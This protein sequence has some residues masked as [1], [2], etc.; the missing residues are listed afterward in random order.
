MSQTDAEKPNF[1]S[2]GTIRALNLPV[3]ETTWAVGE[4][5]RRAQLKEGPKQEPAQQEVEIRREQQVLRRVLDGVAVLSEEI[6]RTGM[7]PPI[8]YV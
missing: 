6:V 4:L 7:V 1:P 8:F 5:G 2:I 3:D